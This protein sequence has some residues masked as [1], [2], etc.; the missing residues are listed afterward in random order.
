M[1]SMP[2]SWARHFSPRAAPQSEAAGFWFTIYNLTFRS[3]NDRARSKPEHDHSRF[4]HRE[5]IGLHPRPRVDR[6]RLEKEENDPAASLCL[7][8]IDDAR[9]P[10]TSR[11]VPRVAVFVERPSSPEPTGGR[12]LGDSQVASERSYREIAWDRCPGQSVRRCSRRPGQ[13]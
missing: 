6:T 1:A 8:A 10:R 13:Q 4:L 3:V 11:A 2:V 12:T 5:P 9:S 7:K